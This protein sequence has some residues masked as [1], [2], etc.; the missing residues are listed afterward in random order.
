M[1]CAQALVI[2]VTLFDGSG[3]EFEAEVSNLSRRE[4]TLS[5]LNS[6]EVDRESACQITMGVAMPKGER[7]KVLVEKLT[8]LGV[9][10]LVPIITERSVAAPKP[11]ALDK[12]RRYVIEASKQCGRNRLMAIDE[13]MKLDAF[14]SQE[15]TGALRLVAHPAQEQSSMNTGSLSECLVA[16]G[17]EG[18]FADQE[19][20]LANQHGWHNLSLGSRIL[21]VETAAL[22]IA[23][24]LTIRN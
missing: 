17:P 3:S 20:M 13:P 12:H 16:V 23:S 22:A 14:L 11:N 5:I 4:A 15:D 9:A 18:G 19:V 1:S 7:Q 10:R 21:R 2:G 6:C 24:M 8:E